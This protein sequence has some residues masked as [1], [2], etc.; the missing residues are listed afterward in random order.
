[1][2]TIREAVRPGRLFHTNVA[3]EPG[4]TLPAWPETELNIAM[5]KFFGTALAVAL[6]AVGTTAWSAPAAAK[7]EAPSSGLV[8]N[9]TVRA[10]AFT[11]REAIAARDYT[12]AQTAIAQAEAAATTDDERYVATLLRYGLES[13]KIA[14]KTMATNGVYDPNPVA[15]PLDALIANPRTPRSELPRYLYARGSVAFDQ[16]KWAQAIDFFTRAQQAG[17]TD[18][19]LPLYLIKTRVESGD[20]AGGLAEL[21]AIWTT[22][23]ERMTEDYYAYAIGRSNKA[24]QKAETMK[25]LRRALAANPTARAWH[26]AVTFYGLQQRA[27]VKLDARQTLD[28]YRLLRLANAL[29]DE[30]DYESYAQAAIEAGVPDEA[31]AAIVAGKAAG[32]FPTPTPAATT[33]LSTKADAAI[34][35]KGPIATLE[36]RAKASPK[37]DLLAQAGDIRLGRGDYAEAAARYR[38]ALAKGVGNADEVNTRLGIALAMAGDKT[39]AKAAFA[40]VTGAPRADIAQLFTTLVDNPTR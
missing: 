16:K 30:N 32:K 5:K 28:L 40:A 35:A 7:K 6:V 31:K 33:A 21:D 12:T 37:G 9:E 3:G 4:N 36:S 23:P 38:D 1:M 13:Q 11:A 24:G 8:L 27:M 29:A 19:N 22:H 25:W 34:R 26:S 18:P 2:S 39:G 14:D 15:A 17:S 20:V 10:A